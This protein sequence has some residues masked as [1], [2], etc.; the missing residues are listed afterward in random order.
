MTTHRDSVELRLAPDFE[1]PALS[2]AAAA[3]LLRILRKAHD[4]D[5]IA[6]LGRDLTDDQ[7][8]A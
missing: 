2:P 3:V 4:R 1:P 5:V 8:V 7:A 6:V